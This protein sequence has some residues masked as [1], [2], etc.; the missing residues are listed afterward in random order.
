[1]KRDSKLSGILHVLLHMAEQT[2][3]VTSES[4]A[5]MMS[6][7]PV[8]IRRTMAGL[9][10]RGY[11]SSVKGHGGGWTLT[12]DLNQLTLAEIW[13][14]VGEP[15]LI[16]LTH[17]QESPGCLVEQV[18]NQALDTASREA[19]ALLIA[20]LGQVTLAQLSEDFHQH[21]AAHLSTEHG[22]KNEAPHDQ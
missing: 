19:E 20:R 1:M 14:A 13:R 21:Y 4:L 12:C 10:E 16:A 8:V 17:R 22:C 3:P 2:T 6:T 11:V 18:V 9:R 15:A 5:Q 7:H